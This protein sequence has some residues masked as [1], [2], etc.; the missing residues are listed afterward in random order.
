MT[1]NVLTSQ[2]FSFLFYKMK[3]AWFVISSY[4]HKGY[5]SHVQVH[6][7]FLDFYYIHDNGDIFFIL[8]TITVHVHTRMCVWV[9][10]LRAGVRGQ[11]C[12][13][14]SIHLYVDY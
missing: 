2:G 1:L 6:H 10:Q 11:F 5:S 8:F 9:C 7:V 3:N 4:V 13:V 14:F 12:G